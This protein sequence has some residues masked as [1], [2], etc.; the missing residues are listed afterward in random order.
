[1]INNANI[2]DFFYTVL[3]NAPYDRKRRVPEKYL[4]QM[5][6]EKK[7]KRFSTHSTMDE[8]LMVLGHLGFHVFCVVAKE[9]VT[10]RKMKEILHNFENKKSA[11][12]LSQVAE[13]GIFITGD[14]EFNRLLGYTAQGSHSPN[15]YL[16]TAFLRA[17]YHIKN[18]SKTN[19]N[20]RD[21]SWRE[22]SE[23][24]RA[25]TGLLLKG[26]DAMQELRNSDS[27]S[28]NEVKI[29][30][31]LYFCTNLE[32]TMDH[33]KKVFKKSIKPAGISTAIRDL[34]SGEFIMK[35]TPTTFVI[36]SLGILAINRFLAYT[37]N[38]F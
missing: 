27:L 31:Y 2:N 24:A 36:S 37:L 7:A 16:N 11:T 30:V 10:L 19:I 9:S 4:K 28:E 18:W 38:E 32:V 13:E 33:V 26:F 20:S 3:F 25:I 15:F 34:I 8:K 14:R 23:S 6:D 35:Y 22:Q 5:L 21:N 29:L 12:A 1:M 17:G